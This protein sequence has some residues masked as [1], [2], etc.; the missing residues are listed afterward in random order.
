MG[1]PGPVQGKRRCRRAWASCSAWRL[2]GATV[3]PRGTS[4]EEHVLLQGQRGREATQL[5]GC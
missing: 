1:S 3:V 4:S 5:P 2:E